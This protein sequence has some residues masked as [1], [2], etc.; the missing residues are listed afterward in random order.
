M[1]DSLDDAFG[2]LGSEIRISI[3][4]IL[5]EADEPLP[6]SE[7]RSRV[8]V[9]DSGQFN[10]HLD[11]IRGRY[12]EKTEDGYILTR[13]G[14]RVT[15][16]I[17]SSAYSEGTVIGP[18]TASTDCPLCGADQT[19]IYENSALRVHCSES[20]DH[21]WLSPLPPG[22]TAGRDL[23]ELIEL[24]TSVNRHHG[25]LARSGTC[26]QCFGQMDREMRSD[27]EVV[28]RFGDHD[29]VFQATCQQCSLPIGGAVGTLVTLHPAV[30]STYH[31]HGIDVREKTILPHEFVPPTVVSEDPLRLRV[32]VKSPNKD[33]SQVVVQLTLDETGNIVT[34]SETPE[35]E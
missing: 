10:Y 32:D 12:V 8:D 33:E 7:I 27:E 28:R 1:S 4:R 24:G 17:V 25:E 9:R 29:Y 31:E 16:A 30:V 3:L 22:A 23:D 13:A 19:V 18:E 14:L 21:R 34:V 26:P 2:A 6:F 20:D 35:K 15:G 11:Q 5:G